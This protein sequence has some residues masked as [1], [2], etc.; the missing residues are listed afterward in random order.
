MAG[1][2]TLKVSILADVADLLKG[3]NTGE[4]ELSSFG[5]KMADFGKKAAVALAAAATAAAAFAVKFGKDA[6]NAASDLNETIS[7]TNVLF[8]DASEAIIEFAQTS[9][10]SLGQSTQQ[11]LDAA[12]TFAT[13][14]KSAGLAGQDLVDFSK[15]FVVL[16]SDLA[17]FN[18][19]SP[20]EAIQ[21]IG[22]ALRGEAE[23]LR[24]YGVLLDDA[25][26][27]QKAL[28]LGIVSTT[29]NA[30]T[31]QQKVLAAQALI[32]EQ[33]GAAQ[34]D[35]A[36]TSD[37]LANSQRILEAQL[38][39]VTTQVGTALLPIMNEFMSFV[40][41]KAIPF[42]QE[43]ASKFNDKTGQSLLGTFKEVGT[44]IV[45]IFGP[46]WNGLKSAFDKI[47]TAIVKNKDDFQPLLDTFK[48][49]YEF[50]KTTFIPAG[51]QVLGNTFSALG[52]I[53]AKVIDVTSGAVNF[54]AKGIQFAVNAAIA[55]IN[56]LIR[57]YNA[58]PF[59]GDVKQLSGVSF[60]SQTFT[61][62]PNLQSVTVPTMPTG[63]GGTGGGGTGGGGGASGGGKVD[64]ATAKLQETM[65]EVRITQYSVQ[66]TLAKLDRIA[67]QQLTSMD[68]YD[69]ASTAPVINF[70]APVVS[71]PETLARLVSD[72]LNSSANRTG[73]YA[74]LGIS[75]TTL[76][77]AAL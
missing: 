32:F 13:F 15:D 74:T 40:G 34:G 77:A 21:A 19:T 39:N 75:T 60:A 22:A 1:S 37:G 30:L 45:Q 52:T 9:A 57:A 64:P 23:P 7:K 67:A 69:R 33:T 28:E 6:I 59:L 12:A 42:I 18:N 70:N 11:A 25:S 35:F 16:A 55:G 54:V 61:G 72:T 20:E 44:Y 8:G 51:L 43:L 49:L 31:P 27:R 56:A 24:R 29:K 63:T 41:S 10:S 3:L 53:I 48:T 4:K 38:A 66:E 36:R 68:F 58:V 76:P 5:D 73:N 47:S 26:M 62:N 2:R 50:I 46:L 14:G 17:S 65:D 71:D